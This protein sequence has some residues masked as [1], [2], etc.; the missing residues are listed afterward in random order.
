MV[1]AETRVAEPERRER[2]RREILERVADALG[3]P[4]DTVVL[5]RPGSVLKTSSGKVRRSGTR[6]A[7]RAGTLE[8][9]AGS[10]AR[11]W[12][13]MAWQA[14]RGHGRRALDV[15]LRTAYTLHMVG[16]L[17][18]LVPPLWV[19]VR[20]SPRPDS[21]RRWLRRFARLLAAASLSR[22]TASGLEHLRS[23]GPA[24]FVA[25]HASF[26]DVVVVLATLP[27]SIRFAAKGRLA[28]YPILR[29]II[30]RG[31]YLRIEKTGLSQRMEGAG[32]VGTTLAAGESMFVFPEGRF[33]RAPGLL[34]FRLGAFRAAA[35]AGCPVVPVALAGTRRMFPAGTLLLRP[36]RIHVAVGP[37]LQPRS[38]DW[39]E[40]VRLRDEARRAIG[41]ETG[42][43]SAP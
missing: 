41:R 6:D 1:V 38:A 8:R 24:V 11:Q 39:S 14:A 15:L 4:P 23:L 35:E 42:E 21:A 20:A 19:L 43:E 9:G 28:T 18:V 40:V 7:Y 3:V 22:V 30:R 16:L 32:E 34:P 12:V 31:G 25:N 27:A 26:A 10:L 37:P 2:M 33:V 29:T 17:V 36:G 13:V 5:A